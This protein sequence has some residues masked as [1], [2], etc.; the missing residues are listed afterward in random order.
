MKVYTK[1]GDKGTTALFGG[2]RV[3]KHHI[4]IESYGTVDELNSYIGLIRDQEMNPLYKAVLIE[5]QDRLFTLGAILA[6]PPEKEVLKNGRKRLQNLGLT[7]TDIEYLENEIDKMETDLPPMT[8]FVLPG[9]HTTVSHC[10]IARCVCRRAERL[11]THLHE[12]EPTDDLVLK[13]LN[14]LSDYLFVLARKLSHDLNANE[15]PWIPRK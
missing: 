4:R 14:R 3:P 11:A 15:V 7:E 12:E 9:G 5:V 10:H 13:Y 6:T 2:T 8:H 1:T